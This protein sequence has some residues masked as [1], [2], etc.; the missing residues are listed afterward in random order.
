VQ[1]VFVF[2]LTFILIAVSLSQGIFVGY[3]LLTGL[4]L[5][6]IIAF[7]RGTPFIHLIAYWRSGVQ[8][9]LLVIKIFLLIGGLTA[10]WMT[11]GT[12]PTIVFYSLQVI[13]PSFFYLIAFVI[14]CLVS[15]LIGTSLGTAGTLGV[16]MMM[17]ARSGQAHLPLAAG[18]LIAGAYFGD[19]FSPMSSSANL[20]ASITGTRLFDNLGNMSRTM[21][22]PFLLSTLIYLIFS[23]RYPLQLTGTDIDRLLQMSFV[24]H[25][26]ALLPALVML[27]LSS[28]RIGVK[29]SMSLSLITAVLLAFFMQNR[30]PIEVLQFLLAGFTLAP[31]DPLYAIIRG[32][33][34]MSMVRPAIIVLASCALAEVIHGAHFLDPVIQLLL[35]ARTRFQL[36]AATLVTSLVSGGFGGT[37]AVAV[38]LTAHLMQEPYRACEAGKEKLALDLEDTAIILP[39]LI[40]WNIASLLPTTLLQM[41]RISFIPFAFFLYLLPLWN[42]L[43]YRFHHQ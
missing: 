11:A 3:P 7:Y 34:L 25:P 38:V 42:L 8:K 21:P 36:F 1:I 4:F 20:V 12:V 18:A 32:G 22:I 9:S 27:A 16:A 41:D 2:I 10:A 14:S 15:F 24:I 26:L 19:R 33:G 29:R 43:S 28:L 5:F 13:H 30:S 6:S 37:Q 31:S 35:K 23:L 40:P 39:A 17:V